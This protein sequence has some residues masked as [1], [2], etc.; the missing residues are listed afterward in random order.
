MA[1]WDYDSA[2]DVDRLG[3]APHVIPRPSKGFFFGHP[4]SRFLVESGER[5]KLDRA[6]QLLQVAANLG[7]ILSITF[8]AFELSQNRDMMRAQTRND[9]SQGVIELLVV[10]ATDG[11]LFNI[12][13]RGNAGEELSEDEQ[14]RFNTMQN[15]FFRYWE[16]MHYQYRN[17]LTTRLSLLRK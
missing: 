6:N 4:Q 16:N 15:A 8:L 5:M 11:E 10:Q 9:L 17:G 14:G 12:L 3:P 1:G 13:R 7:V 2:L